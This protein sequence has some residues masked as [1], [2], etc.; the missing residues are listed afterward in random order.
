METENKK[1]ES[2]DKIM[3]KKQEK[4]VDTMAKNYAE[5]LE[6]TKNFGK[7]SFEKISEVSS[8]GANFIKS[9]HYWESLK[10]GSQKIKEKTSEQGLEFKKNSPKFYKKITNS[11]FYFFETIVGR[12]K[13]GT[14]YGAP[15]LEILERLAKLNELGI[16]T[17]E[18]FNRKKKKLLERI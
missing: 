18:E 17:K 2:G 8:S 1:S 15:S 7:E 5:T 4:F 12:I 6:H 9:K 10:S 11:F 16:I 14:Q 3:Q 13:L